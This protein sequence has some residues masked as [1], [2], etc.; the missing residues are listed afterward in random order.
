MNGKHAGTGD[1]CSFCPGVSRGT[2]GE[3]D[4]CYFRLSCANLKYAT[5]WS[6]AL[7]TIAADCHNDSF[8]FLGNRYSSLLG[9]TAFDSYMLSAMSFAS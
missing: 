4:L 6:T 7:N 9:V 1:L 8:L 2:H 5:S 3:G